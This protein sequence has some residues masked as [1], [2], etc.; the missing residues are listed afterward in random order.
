ME[1]CPKKLAIFENTRVGWLWTTVLDENATD[2]PEVVLSQ[3]VSP[4]IAN[5]SNCH[6]PHTLFPQGSRGILEFQVHVPE[7][8]SVR[9]EKACVL[10]LTP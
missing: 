7:F 8:S 2:V 4:V 10:Q 6:C 5:Q 1:R 9:E 3:A